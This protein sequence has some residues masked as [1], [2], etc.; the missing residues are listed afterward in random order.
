MKKILIAGLTTALT[1][2]AFAGTDLYGFIKASY[3]S[4]TEMENDH[5]AFYANEDRIASEDD[6]NEKAHS[7]FS[8]KQSRFG[9]KFDN[10]SKTSGKIEFDFDGQEANTA[11]TTNSDSGNLRTRLLEISYKVG[12][13]GTLNFGKR[14]DTFAAFNPHTY[15][16]TMVQLKQGNTG[17]LNESL[18]YSHKIND[19]KAYFQLE[20]QGTNNGSATQP[21][22][23]SSPIMTV[24][25]DY[26]MDQHLVGFAHKTGALT[27][28]DAAETDDISISGT[29]LFYK[30]SFG[31]T[32]L[33]AEYF[34]GSNLGYAV[35]GAGH[36]A[37]I[38]AED[39][40]AETGYYISAKHQLEKFCLFVGYGTDKITNEEDVTLG[41]S[42]ATNSATRFG[43][44]Y[45][46]DTN[47]KFFAEVTQVTTG[48]LVGTDIEDE[49]GSMLDVGMLYKF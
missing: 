43:V 45:A 24:K 11:G 33:V 36:G 41:G 48:Y 1:T 19:V 39:D 21:Q 14:W 6:Y 13:N 35:S 31:A 10:G 16:V 20:K 8:T 17:F 29:K 49:S 5:K 47:L 23:V 22:T 26:T 15:S 25:V 7:S 18:E 4:N 38:G 40:V 3:L 28:E 27:F 9:I 37:K 30:G 32:S 46:A 34:V 44:D 12:E 2:S 42:I